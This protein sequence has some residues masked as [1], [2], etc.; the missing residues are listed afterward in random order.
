[1]W[2]LYL[3]EPLLYCGVNN[4]TLTIAT[5]GFPRGPMETTF[6]KKWFILLLAQSLSE[7]V[8]ALCC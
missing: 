5:N 2:H 8:I 7:N 6:E 4:L 3:W 1:M